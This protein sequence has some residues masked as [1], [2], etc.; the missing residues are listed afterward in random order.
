M[1]NRLQYE[2]TRGGHFFRRRIC[3]ALRCQDL[4]LRYL[5]LGDRQRQRASLRHLLR[6]LRQEDLLRAVIHDSWVWVFRRWRLRGEEHA[7]LRHNLIRL[8]IRWRVDGQLQRR[9]AHLTRF[10]ASHG[11]RKRIRRPTG[12]QRTYLRHTLTGDRRRFH[13]CLYDGGAQ[14]AVINH[15]LLN[16]HRGRCHSQ[17]EYLLRVDDAHGLR[18][19]GSLHR[20]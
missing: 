6:E 1:L 11:T 4:Q 15:A 19:L 18:H 13:A 8:D 14:L 5:R 12:H 16:V 3:R 2:Q 17:V 20:L 7:Q 9:D 10:E